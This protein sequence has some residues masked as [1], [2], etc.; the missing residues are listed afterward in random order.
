MPVKSVQL[1]QIWRH[2]STGKLYLV[3]KLYR[4][5]FAEFA[6]LREANVEPGTGDSTRVRVSKTSAGATLPGYAFTQDAGDF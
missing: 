4:E 6:M 5:V 1:G 2:E 3:T